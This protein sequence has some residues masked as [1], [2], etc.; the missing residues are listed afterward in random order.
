MLGCGVGP[1]RAHTT[2][3]NVQ[4]DG[5]HQWDVVINGATPLGGVLWPS[6]LH[7][8]CLE[9]MQVAACNNDRQDGSQRDV[10]KKHKGACNAFLRKASSRQHVNNRCS[11]RLIHVRS[12]T[13]VQQYR[14]VIP[15]KCN[16][17]HP[18]TVI[19]TCSLTEDP[20][21]EP[22]GFLSGAQFRNQTTCNGYGKLLT[23]SV[24]LELMRGQR[25]ET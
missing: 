23:T 25:I 12:C 14:F 6:R 16:S 22:N 15:K 20:A 19:N 7:L 10:D 4:S 21:T 24:T 11:A 2:A 13:F 17:C 8:L 5:H 18:V 9:Q 3:L 1:D